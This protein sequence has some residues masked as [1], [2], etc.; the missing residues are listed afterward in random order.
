MMTI[1]SE[2][3]YDK[4]KQQKIKPVSYF[5]LV[6]NYFLFLFLLFLVKITVYLYEGQVTK[7]KLFN[8]GPGVCTHN[9][10]AQTRMYYWIRFFD[11]KSFECHFHFC[12]SICL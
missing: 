2:H 7:K 8:N 11:V 10:P 12:R 4:K 1:L 3:I 5:Y 9:I 6:I